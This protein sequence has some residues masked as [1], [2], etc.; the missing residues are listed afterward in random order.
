[1][2]HETIH[3]YYAPIKKLSIVHTTNL[4]IMLMKNNEKKQFIFALNQV[5]PIFPICPKNSHFQNKNGIIWLE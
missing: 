3:E 1:M 4:E 5:P 2:H